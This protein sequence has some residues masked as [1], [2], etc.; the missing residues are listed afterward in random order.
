AILLPFQILIALVWLSG[1]S[2]QIVLTQSASVVKKPGESHKLQ[3]TTSG[4]TLSSSWMH[5]IR[6]KPGK[7]LE[8][9][10][11]YLSESSKN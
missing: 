9:L 4:F 8:W 6:Q 2:S 5:W 10:V 1:A 3:C 7:G 11:K